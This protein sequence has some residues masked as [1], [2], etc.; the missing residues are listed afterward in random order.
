M[1]QGVRIWVLAVVLGMGSFAVAWAAWHVWQD[2]QAVHVL[3]GIETQ[4]QQM[5]QQQR[6]P[7]G[8]SV[9]PAPDPKQKKGG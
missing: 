7:A 4:R 8:E 1:T 5:I 3:F 9:V 2:H 6:Q